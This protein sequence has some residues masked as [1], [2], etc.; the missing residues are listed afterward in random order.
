MQLQ[1]RN[2]VRSIAES[3]NHLTLQITMALVSTVNLGWISLFSLRDVFD[4]I[5]S[6]KR[7]PAR[8]RG[9]L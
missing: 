5:S 3:Y 9:K 7:H 4:H 8:P 1:T 6:I 2:L